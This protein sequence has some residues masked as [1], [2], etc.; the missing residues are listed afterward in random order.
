MTPSFIQMSPGCYILVVSPMITGL[1]VF[2]ALEQPRLKCDCDVHNEWIECYETSADPRFQFRR[3]QQ[4]QYDNSRSRSNVSARNLDTESLWPQVVNAKRKHVI[5][6]QIKDNV[7]K[8]PVTQIRIVASPTPTITEN[9]FTSKKRPEMTVLLMKKPVVRI[10]FLRSYLRISTNANCLQSLV[11]KP[12]LLYG[13]MTPAVDYTFN[14]KV[15]ESIASSESFCFNNF[16]KYQ[17]EICDHTCE[18]GSDA[19]VP[20]VSH[21]VTCRPLED[22]LRY[23]RWKVLCWPQ[24]FS[25]RADFCYACFG[26]SV[27]DKLNGTAEPNCGSQECSVCEFPLHDGATVDITTAFLHGDMEEEVYM[28]CPDGIDLIEEGWNLDDDFVELLRTIYGTKQAARQYRKKFMNFMEAKGFERTHAEQCLLKRIDN[29]GTVV[30]CVYVDDCLLT[31]DRK[32]IDVAM[33]D[34]ESAFETR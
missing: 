21:H 16:D 6:K 22:P 31:G 15:R 12:E 14:E 9:R 33:E 7:S 25:L 3:S 8:F 24:V 19:A 29:N 1:V 20:D 13:A 2:I 26:W 27:Y 34:I 10:R 18:C 11:P 32:A 30:I 5:P 23:V 28:K 4:Q 17:K